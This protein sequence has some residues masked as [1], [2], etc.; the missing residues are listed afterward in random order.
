LYITL[1]VHHPKGPKEKEILVAA[2]PRLAEVNSKHKGFIQQ[3]VAEVEDE[4]LVIPFTI[5]E[6][7]EDYNAALKDTVAHLF[8]PETTA[9]LTSVQEGP[10]RGGGSAL[11]K[12]A[13]ITFFKVAP[14]KLPGSSAAET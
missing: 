9:F 10:T 7:E 2:Q 8:S 11:S 12:E 13:T 6:S 5:W 4:N 1:A 3:V 14:V